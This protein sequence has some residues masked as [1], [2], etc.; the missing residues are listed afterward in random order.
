LVLGDELIFGRQDQVHHLLIGL[1]LLAFAH[2]DI[3]TE[4]HFADI[5]EIDVLPVEVHGL[6][7]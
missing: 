1:L 5:C 4:V 3:P 7:A 2:V 6:V